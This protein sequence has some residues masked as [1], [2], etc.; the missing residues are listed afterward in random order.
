MRESLEEAPCDRSDPTERITVPHVLWSGVLSRE[1]LEFGPSGSF[2][3]NK[4]LALTCWPTDVRRILE[5]LEGKNVRIVLE[6]DR[7]ND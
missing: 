2:A 5:S 3:V 4:K 7:G 6:I 1:I